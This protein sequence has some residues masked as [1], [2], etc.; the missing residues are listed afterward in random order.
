MAIEALEAALFFAPA[1]ETAAVLRAARDLVRHT[2]SSESIRLV[3]L[4]EEQSRII[5]TT[6]TAGFEEQGK[7]LFYSNDL[8]CREIDP[9]W[10]LQLVFSDLEAP[11][12]AML[13]LSP[14][15]SGGVSTEPNW[16]FLT[17]LLPIVV[18]IYRPSL[19]LCNGMSSDEEIDH[20]P[21][22]E[23]L[24]PGE[25]PPVITP[26]FYLGADRLNASLRKKLANL[27]V[28]RSEPL[29]DGWLLQVV[30][31][32]ENKPSRDVIKQLQAAGPKN[33]RYT[34]TR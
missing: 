22:F 19:A 31:K 7:I 34:Q 12:Q 23:E 21:S 17:D 8:L 33:T 16:A 11:R 26:W 25:F 30:E 18:D 13:N 1:P 27:D 32:Y 10:M 4:D 6:D 3:P 28:A 5:D 29:G 9:D 14:L 2:A 15:P 20:L 24:S